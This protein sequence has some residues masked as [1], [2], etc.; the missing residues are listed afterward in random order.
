MIITP[1]YLSCRWQMENVDF[2]QPPSLYLDYVLQPWFYRHITQTGYFVC[3]WQTLLHLMVI[4]LNAQLGK[5]TPAVQVYESILGVCWYSSAFLCLKPKFV[6]T[7]PHVS[8]PKIISLKRRK[9]LNS[10]WLYI[11]IVYL[12]KDDIK[13]GTEEWQIYKISLF[14]SYLDKCIP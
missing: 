2:L 13:N 11:D 1:G 6:P 5:V 14:T 8:L 9:A 10:G 4:M 12:R 3:R 7:S